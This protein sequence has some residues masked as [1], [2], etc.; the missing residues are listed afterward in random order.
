MF[1]TTFYGVWDSVCL[2]NNQGEL[3]VYCGCKPVAD[4]KYDFES[5]R[6]ATE[7]I[8]WAP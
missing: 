7:A 6:S 3:L 8:I 5:N 1:T 4:A 2:M